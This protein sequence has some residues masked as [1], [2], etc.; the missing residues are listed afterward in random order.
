M[1]LRLYYNLYFFIGILL[2]ILAENIQNYRF[3]V[4]ISA[5]PIIYTDEYKVD[6]YNR[7]SE[8]LCTNK[9]CDILQELRNN[10]KTLEQC[11]E[12]ICNWEDLLDDEREYIDMLFVCGD[13]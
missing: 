11:R 10:T 9:F 2:Y 8:K 7:V 13:F 1:K 4:N 6:L 5:N 12:E 3:T